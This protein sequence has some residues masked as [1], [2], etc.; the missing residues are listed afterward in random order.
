MEKSFHALWYPLWQCLHFPLDFLH[1][2]MIIFIPCWYIK[3]RR[4]KSLKYLYELLI[5]RKKCEFMNCY[6]THKFSSTFL[7]KY[8]KLEC[9]ASILLTIPI[10]IFSLASTFVFSSLGRCVELLLFFGKEFEASMP[11]KWHAKLNKT[12]KRKAKQSRREKV[13]H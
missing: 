8:L 9:T 2:S 6:A 3:C 10:F 11:W 12:S 13:T 4:R 1:F 7:F 5:T